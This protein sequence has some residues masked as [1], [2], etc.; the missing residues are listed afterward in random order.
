MAVKYCEK[1]KAE[2]QMTALEC[3]NCAGS[4]FVS[5]ETLD[6]LH[7]A[8]LKSVGKPLPTSSTSGKRK[9]ASNLSEPASSEFESAQG[10]PRGNSAHGNISL[11]IK[12]HSN[13]A[14]IAIESARIVNAYGAYIQVIGMVFGGVIVIAGFVLAHTSGS[15][16]VGLVGLVIGALDVAIFAV[17]GAIFRMISNYVIAR[18]E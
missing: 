16:I 11:S 17:Q 7:A 8:Y 18:L 12:S 2:V 4:S 5:T 14:R 9:A 13:S 10:N 1:C 15:A 3:P 6:D